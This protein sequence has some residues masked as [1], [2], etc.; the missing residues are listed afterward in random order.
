MLGLQLVKSLDV[1]SWLRSILPTTTAATPQKRPH[2]VPTSIPSPSTISLINPWETLNACL[3]RDGAMNPFHT[4]FD[5]SLFDIDT[6]NCKNEGITNSLGRLETFGASDRRAVLFED[7]ALKTAMQTPHLADCVLMDANQSTV[8]L[9]APSYEQVSPCTILPSLGS[10]QGTMVPF[11]AFF[12]DHLLSNEVDD[13]PDTK[14]DSIPILEGR[15]L[16]QLHTRPL[17][18]DYQISG[19]DILGNTIATTESDG[20]SSLSVGTLNKEDGGRTS[21]HPSTTTGESFSTLPNSPYS[22]R[23]SSWATSISTHLGEDDD[24]DSNLDDTRIPM[25]PDQN[26][27]G[28]ELMHEY[29]HYRHLIE[30][31]NSHD[32]RDRDFVAHEPVEERIYEVTTPESLTQAAGE[33]A[34]EARGGI[35]SSVDA[36]ASTMQA[37]SGLVE[38]TMEPK[39]ACIQPE[40]MQ[41]GSQTT[42]NSESGS[43][44]APP[45][46]PAEAAAWAHSFCDVD[47]ESVKLKVLTDDS[48]R[49]YV[50]YRDCFH[51]V[52]IESAPE[53]I[54][55]EEDDDY[56][57]DGYGSANET[58]EAVIDDVKLGTIPEEEDEG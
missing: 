51:C 3:Q 25:K 12:P 50:L 38:E 10:G 9:T 28:I 56:D 48:G 20:L 27:D 24:D 5:Q 36:E 19:Q 14:G 15:P 32:R 21:P 47:P 58:C 13:L 43:E 22:S 30:L 1:T 29:Q 33:L 45:A 42:H 18:H 46:T 6:V 16:C 52:P 40:S 35:T 57:D 39:S 26:T 31:G 55:V 54:E 4:L 37:A 17:S 34:G 41:P 53:F 44:S 23:R 8:V 49:E 7:Y 11:R 2:V